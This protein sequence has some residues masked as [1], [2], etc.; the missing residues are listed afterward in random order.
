M[1]TLLGLEMRR[2]LDPGGFSTPAE[3]QANVMYGSTPMDR[4]LFDG[5]GSVDESRNWNGLQIPLGISMVTNVSLWLV[6]HAASGSGN[7]KWGVFIKSDNE[8]ERPNRASSNE[9]NV[10][11]AAPDTDLVISTMEITDYTM[12]AGRNLQILLGRRATS[13]EDT[14]DSIDAIVLGAAL[15]EL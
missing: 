10:I 2:S 11:A 7:V 14:L 15:V 6:W 8:G 1:R 5:A 3:Y 13:A 4:L 9:A 12:L